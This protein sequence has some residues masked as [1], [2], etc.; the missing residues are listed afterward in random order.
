LFQLDALY[1][2]YLH[3]LRERKLVP[4]E[5]GTGLEEAVAGAD[6]Q[7]VHRYKRWCRSAHGIQGDCLGGA[8]VAGKYLDLQGRYMWAMAL[9]RSP[10]GGVREGAGRTGA[11]AGGHPGRDVHG[12]HVVGF[13]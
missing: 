7:W 2:G 9:R 3:L 10:A 13:S 8:L 5:E 1:G 11:H 6:P 4:L 12:G